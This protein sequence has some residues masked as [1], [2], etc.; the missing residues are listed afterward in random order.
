MDESL[1]KVTSFADQRAETYRYWR[2]RPSQERFEATWEMSR[3][4]YAE[5]YRSKG[6]VHAEGPT[7]SFTRIQ[8]A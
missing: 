5:Y 2:S 4:M 3:E 8:R 6:T 1:K 7:R